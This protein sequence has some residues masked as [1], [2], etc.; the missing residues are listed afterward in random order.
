MKYLYFYLIVLL[1]FIFSCN[2]KSDPILAQNFVNGWNENLSLNIGNQTRYFRV[3]QPIGI[4]ASAPVVIL[5]HGGGQS[6]NDLFEPTAGGT[7]VWTTVADNEKFLLVVPNGFDATANNTSGNNQNWNDCRPLTNAN[8]GYSGQDDVAFISE[9]IEWTKKSF[10]VDNTRFYATGVS[11]G[12]LLCYRL[13]AE[14]N[15]KIAAVAPFIANQP[16]PNECTSPAA[17]MPMMICVGTLDP[18]MPFLGGNVAITNRGTVLSAAETLTFWLGANG[19]ASTDFVLT[20]LADSNPS[21]NSTVVKRAYGSSNPAKEIEFYTV[22]G[23]GHCMPSIANPLS[24][25][26]QAAVGPQNQDIEGALVAWNFL[27][28]HKK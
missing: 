10:N 11:N 25:S 24:T 1:G 21:D 8:P 19:V 2:K 9:L 5:L 20:N 4:A 12:G 23:G 17:P 18:L 28:R 27:K 22:V 16:S 14:L 6:M 3:Y 26:S 15:S 13:A 7:R